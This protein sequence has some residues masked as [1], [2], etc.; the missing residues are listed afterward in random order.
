MR[1]ILPNGRK[2]FLVSQLMWIVFVWT[3]VG[4]LDALNIDALIKSPIVIGRPAYEFK[5]YLFVKIFSAFFSG[6]LSG[7]ILVFFLRERARYV[8]MGFAL[9]INSAIISM[10]NFGIIAFVHRF[11]LDL[12]YDKL[13][14]FLR[15]FGLWTIVTVLTIVFMHVNDKFGHRALLKLLS[16]RYY[17]PIEEERIFMFVDIESSTRIAE[18]L[19]HILFFNLL[20]DFFRDITDSI[21]STRGEIYQYVGDQVVISW[22]MKNG[23]I[24]A[25]C[26]QCFYR[27][28]ESIM[29][30]ADK[31]QQKYGLIPEFKAGLHCGTVTVGEI[32]VIKKDIVFSGDVMNTTARIESLCNLYGVKILISKYLLEKLQL[33]PSDFTPERMGIIE[34][35]G[36]KQKVELYTFP[37]YKKD[38]PVNVSIA[39]T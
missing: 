29:L 38:T 36:K 34:L 23:L 7:G 12:D 4:A 13:F 28:Q 2:R 15:S 35:K 33:P 19:G 5:Q 14:F 39:S 6:L 9:I 1:S 32:G 10:L 24:N 11:F 26:V 37:D 16:G 18:K 25:N 31:Y 27:M 30:E 20:N 21:I 17:K 3:V 22:T 8:S